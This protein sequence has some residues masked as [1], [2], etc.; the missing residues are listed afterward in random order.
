MR[1]VAMTW[2]TARLGSRLGLRRRCHMHIRE[3]EWSPVAVAAHFA[4][5]AG[6]G[7]FY[8]GLTSAVHLP[9]FG[10]GV[11]YALILWAGSYLCWLP[12]LG[13]HPSATHQPARRRALMVAAH[14]VWGAA[15]DALLA[16]VSDPARRPP[17]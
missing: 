8:G 9:P 14:V 13:L 15:L 6:A 5:G 16:K 2:G 3:A 10:P 11:A 17:H 1:H 7:L 12:A 4:Y